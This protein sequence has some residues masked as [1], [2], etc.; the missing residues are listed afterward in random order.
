MNTYNR[1]KWDRVFRWFTRELQVVG[2]HLDFSIICKSG[3]WEMRY[4]NDLYQSRVLNSL[5]D[6]YGVGFIFK[7]GKGICKNKPIKSKFL[8]L[9]KEEP[10]TLYFHDKQL[11][12]EIDK[13]KNYFYNY[14]DTCYI[15][16]K[17]H[18]DE[19]EVLDCEEHVSL[20]FLATLLTFESWE[21][22]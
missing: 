9:N 20:V 11:V 1:Y 12:L 22:W 17:E 2:T 15:R 19:F 21:L 4:N 16:F 10:Q 7:N 6:K 8:P 3:F 18:N 5:L 14:E 13:D